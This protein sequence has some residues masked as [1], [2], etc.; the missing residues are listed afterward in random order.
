[1]FR[2]ICCSTMEKSGSI[3]TFLWSSS[4]IW[5][6]PLSLIVWSQ[7]VFLSLFKHL[8]A[9]RR[10]SLPLS[11]VLSTWAQCKRW[12]GRLNFS[13]CQ[14]YHPDQTSSPRAFVAWKYRDK[15]WLLLPSVP[16]FSSEHKC[17]NVVFVA[18]T[19]PTWREVWSTVAHTQWM[20]IWVWWK[21][22]SCI[23]PYMLPGDE[24]LY[25]GEVSSSKNQPT[26]TVGFIIYY[27][28]S[29]LTKVTIMDQ[30]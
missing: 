24:D 19:V 14:Y 6:Q 10:S 15:Q 20:R 21:W 5:Q 1:M 28:N 17:K 4:Q 23:V 27:N 30:H 25:F 2:R 16:V 3:Y 13:S 18:P 9:V 7:L 29:T 26:V 8:T 22:M 12:G 11:A